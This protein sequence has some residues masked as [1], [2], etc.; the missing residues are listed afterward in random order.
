MLP[1][2]PGLRAPCGE[3]A[4]GGV[5]GFLEL[6]GRRLGHVCE[7]FLCCGVDDTLC[8]WGRCFLSVD[9]VGTDA[10]DIEDG[11]AGT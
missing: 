10:R 3:G 6:L 5:D 2:L 1:L 9:N 4:L 11:E 7:D 8:C